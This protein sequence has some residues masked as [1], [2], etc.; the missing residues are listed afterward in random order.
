MSIS[1]IPDW[2]Q[3]TTES[4]YDV[5]GTKQ[6]TSE[7]WENFLQSEAASSYV[8]FD[9][10]TQ[11]NV[12]K[13]EYIDD[14]TV[15]AT[16][17]SFLTSKLKGIY[18]S[19]SLNQLSE[20]EILHRQ[21]VYT[22][23]QILQTLIGTIAQTQM[24]TAKT[25]E[26][27]TQKQSNYADLL[28][29]A[30]FYVGEGEIDRDFILKYASQYGYN[31]SLLD[32]SQPD[33][34]AG[35]EYFSSEDWYYSKVT[36]NTNPTA[37]GYNTDPTSTF[38]GYGNL[39]LSDITQYCANAS[40]AATQDS[41]LFTMNGISS[42]DRKYYIDGNGKQQHFD[43][44]SKVSCSFNVHIVG[45]GTVQT[46]VTFSKS[47]D[48]EKT[49]AGAFAAI[50]SLSLTAAE[51][52]TMKNN[53]ASSALQILG[54][55]SVS[56]PL[57]SSTASVNAS[58]S[59]FEAMKEGFES[60]FFSSYRSAYA[61]GFVAHVNAAQQDAINEAIKKKESAGTIA[62]MTDLFIKMQT[63]MLPWEVGSL[64][65][66]VTNTSDQRAVAAL[67]KYSKQ[68]AARNQAMS[69]SIR[70]IKSK[71]DIFQSKRDQLV[72]IV[73]ASTTGRKMTAQLIE[74]LLSQLNSIISA[75]SK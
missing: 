67:S 55:P 47:F 11:K 64:S 74:S 71:M 45:D 5:E 10:T 61:S 54:L 7:L 21:V 24:E 42:T 70:S 51:K 56:T 8:V 17:V 40:E 28:R 69:A 62:R 2:Y 9:P 53:F 75:I 30:F 14:P 65:A 23:F 66:T 46:S 29:K 22:I 34:T 15:K 16:Y 50:D 25:M 19:E 72:Q 1:S 35:S 52:Q 68:R 31:S 4:F 32:T 18:Q 6:D 48:S 49:F 57:A 44:Y 33:P 12:L 73:E 59:D 13:P 26:F 38:L 3:T 41:S 39:T 36:Y 43:F 20:N 37:A 27:S 60:S 58:Q 63:P